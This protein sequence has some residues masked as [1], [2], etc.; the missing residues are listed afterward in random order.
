MCLPVT[1]LSLNSIMT[2]LSMF[3]ETAWSLSCPYLF[4]VHI[5][6]WESSAGVLSL[7]IHVFSAKF[8]WQVGATEETPMAQ[9]WRDQAAE[10][11]QLC[12]HN[13]H[14]YQHHGG[15]SKLNISQPPGF[16]IHQEECPATDHYNQLVSSPLK[17][18]QEN[19]T[20]PISTCGFHR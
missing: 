6:L 16:T 5:H 10:W 13:Q 18:Q 3:L 15:H 11:D 17:F 1:T 4:S 19:L 2:F 12:C 20:F 7:W 9:Y 8:A 14:Q